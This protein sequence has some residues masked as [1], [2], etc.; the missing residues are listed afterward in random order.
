[1]ED[2]VPRGSEQEPELITRLRRVLRVRHY[3]ATTE[4]AYVAWVR[5]YLRFHE[6]RVPAAL[7]KAEVERFLTHL[8]EEVEVSAS[9]QNQ[10]LA[11]LLLFYEKVLH[12]DL[13]WLDQVVRAKRMKRVPVVLSRAEIDAV[14]CHLRP[15]YYLIALLL[16]GS[17]LRLNECLKL[18]RKDIDFE[19]REIAVQD[20]KGRRARVALLPK[21]AVKPLKENLKHTAQWH[22]SDLRSGAGYVELPHALA[23]KFPNASR[24]LKWQWLFPARR[25]Y[26]HPASGETRRHHL[27]PSSVQRV[28][29]LAVEDA[30]IQKHAGCHTFRHSFATHLLE[31]GYDIRTI[32]KLLGH[33]DVST[34][35]IYTHVLNSGPLGVQSPLD[36]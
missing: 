36:R 11:S 27:H 5:R 14:L 19:R 1:M 9:T 32:Q 18:R 24:A 21:R 3:S 17:G 13:P 28:V 16:Y 23:R 30:G 25:H 31:A 29:K 8:A 15:P 12:A 2:E 35:M 33:K 26:Q 7:G 34:T 20:P 6:G 10:A 4:K 22:R